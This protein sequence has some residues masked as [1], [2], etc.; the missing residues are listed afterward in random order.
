MPRHPGDE[1]LRKIRRVG[2]A[3]WKRL[4]GYH[5][6]S[7]AETTMFWLR[8]AFGG[9]VSSQQKGSIADHSLFYVGATTP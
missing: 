9:K 2:R 8:T 1:N 7:I 5:R 4:I 3:K 6:R